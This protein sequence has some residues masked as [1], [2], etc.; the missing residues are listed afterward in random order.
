MLMEAKNQIKVCLLSCKYALQREMLNKVTFISNILFMILN[1]ASFIIQ[2]IIL[3]SLKDNVGGYTLKQVILLWGIAAGT[4]GFS[5][6]FFNDSY[7]LSDTI[8][9]G[10]LDTFIIQPKNVLLSCITSSVDISAIGDLLYGYIMLLIYGVTP[11]TFLLFTLFCITG[12]FI[13][14]AIAVIT[15]SLS[16]WFGKVELF[17]NT[18]NSFMLNFSTYPEGI[19]KGLIKILFYTIIPIGFV[20]YIPIQLIMKFN[21]VNLIVILLITLLFIGLSFLIF[22]K[23]LKKYSSSNLMN[24]RI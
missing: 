3:Y 1:N 10:K 12:G 24:T 16:F 8:N 6:F 19:F 20:N 2:W 17:V 4:Y 11:I 9:T 15:S 22:N 18:M 5:H 13:L 23:G 21:I 14:T 7:Y